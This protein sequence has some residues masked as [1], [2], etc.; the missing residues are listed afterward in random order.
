MNREGNLDLTSLRIFI[1]TA[2]D[3][4]MTRAAAAL[5]I[6]QPA[7]SAAIKKIENSLGSPVFDRDRRPIQLTTAGRLLWN[8]SFLILEQLDDLTRS[9]QFSLENEKPD[10]RLGASDCM[11][12]CVCPSLI[13]YLLNETENISACTGST[14]KVTDL[15]K[16]RAVDIGLSSDSIE[17]VPHFQALHF[18]TRSDASEIKQRTTIWASF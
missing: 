3:C 4:N 10:L 12:A 17:D 13:D 7:V 15:L 2:K 18:L 1:E 11:S 14:P 5:G 9:I 6:S 8:R 16:H